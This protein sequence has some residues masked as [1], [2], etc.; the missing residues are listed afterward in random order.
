MI[1]CTQQYNTPCLK[2]NKMF[3]KMIRIGAFHMCS[4]CFIQEFGAKTTEIKPS[5]KLG[6]KYYKWLRKHRKKYIV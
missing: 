3:L 6:Y 2:C 1:K 5:S 4:N